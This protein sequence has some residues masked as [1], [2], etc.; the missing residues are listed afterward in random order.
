MYLRAF[1]PMGALTSDFIGYLFKDGEEHRAKAYE[2]AALP[3][4]K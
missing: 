1:K 4:S 2:F 3:A